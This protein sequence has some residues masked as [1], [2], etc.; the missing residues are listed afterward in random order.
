M[1]SLPLPLEIKIVSY[2]DI[3]ANFSCTNLF[4]EISSFPFHSSS[5][6]PFHHSYS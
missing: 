3:T 4:D 2:I 6:F 1:D 5:P